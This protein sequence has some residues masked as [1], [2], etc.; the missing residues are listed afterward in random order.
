MNKLIHGECLE[1][2][3]KLEDNSIDLILC[4][5]PYGTTR[6]KWDS[7]IDL[8]LLWSELKRVRKD[9][10]AV[11]LFA[12]QP[13]TSALIMSNVKE[14]KHEW[15]WDKVT[16]RGHLVAKKRPMQQ[17]ESVVIFGKGGI[18]YNPQMIPLEKATKA[19]VERKRTEL[20]GG[21]GETTN[22]TT[23]KIRTHKYPKTIQTFSMDKNIGHPTQKPI[24]LL[25]YLIKTYSNEQDTV[26][27]MTAGSGSTAIAAINTDRK[28]ICIEKD[29]DYF[30]LMENRVQNHTKQTP[31]TM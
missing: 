30:E 25:E 15:V 2:L 7:V 17:H 12:G 14:F 26:L 27:D 16:A 6:A 3:A 11:V 24:A 31:V 9:D 4:D 8:D 21:I 20:M 28:Y 23:N 13:F 1:E 18:L 29:D 10:R 22:Y 5:L 19:G